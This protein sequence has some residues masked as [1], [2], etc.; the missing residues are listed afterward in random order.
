MF[1]P[2]FAMIVFV[3][4]TTMRE[5]LKIQ[6]QNAEIKKQNDEILRLLGHKPSEKEEGK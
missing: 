4:F 1:L 2:M 6:K 5:L 3:G